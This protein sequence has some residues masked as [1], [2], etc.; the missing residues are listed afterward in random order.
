[1]TALS[2]LSDSVVA[3]FSGER[4]P[5]FSWGTICNWG[6]GARISDGKDSKLGQWCTN[7]L[8]EGFET[9]AMV[10]EILMGRILNWAMVH[11]ILMGR[12]PN[13]AMVHEF[14]IKRI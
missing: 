1:M 10:H 3:D 14:L 13:W 11:E 12:I 9:W 5:N 8:W 6:S 7:F 2:A 4:G